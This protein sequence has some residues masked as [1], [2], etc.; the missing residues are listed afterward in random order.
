MAGQDCVGGNRTSCRDQ[1][2]SVYVFR[3]RK[4]FELQRLGVRMAV[5]D[6]RVQR[7]GDVV[8]PECAVGIQGEICGALGGFAAELEGFGAARGD[9]WVRGDDDFEVIAVELGFTGIFCDEVEG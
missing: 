2:V 9:I 7:T 5:G 6:A 3:V 1:I 4:V 8:A